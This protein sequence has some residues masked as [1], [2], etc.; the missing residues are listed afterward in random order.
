MTRH[1]VIFGAEFE[2]GHVDGG[3]QQL[4]GASARATAPTMTA[5]TTGSFA[6]AKVVA[7]IGTRPGRI[8]VAGEMAG[9][10]R[11]AAIGDRRFTAS[12]DSQTDGLLEARGRVDLW[13]GPFTVCGL[14]GVDLVHTSNVSVGV[15][16][17]FYVGG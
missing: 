17:G 10:I 5:A 2:W 3:A 1:R 7:G 13:L 14:A 8:S 6:A 16:V 11:I 15:L 4:D 12:S 9:G